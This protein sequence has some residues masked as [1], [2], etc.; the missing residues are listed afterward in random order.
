MTEAHTKTQLFTSKTS[1]SGNYLEAIRTFAI[2]NN[3]NPKAEVA[4]LY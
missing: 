4:T 3:I 1:E 2:S